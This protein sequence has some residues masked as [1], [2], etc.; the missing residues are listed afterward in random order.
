MRSSLLARVLSRALPK[1]CVEATFP[2]LSETVRPRAR[3]SLA[4]YS[5]DWGRTRRTVAPVPQQTPSAQ[6]GTACGHG[7]GGYAIDPWQNDMQIHSLAKWN[8][9]GKSVPKLSQGHG[10]NVEQGTW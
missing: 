2:D 3:I 9:R 10:E 1:S 8:S 7:R 5:T 4:T 6:L